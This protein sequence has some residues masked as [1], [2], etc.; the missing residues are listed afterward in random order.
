MSKYYKLKSGS[1]LQ[2]NYNRHLRKLYER[3]FNIFPSAVTMPIYISESDIPKRKS[4]FFTELKQ[5]VQETID[6]AYNTLDEAEAQEEKNKTQTGT[7]SQ[8]ESDDGQMSI[9]T[10][11][12]GGHEEI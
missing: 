6:A 7:T 10:D 3:R 2:A 12:D 1:T 5:S 4:P 8:R 11:I 9:G